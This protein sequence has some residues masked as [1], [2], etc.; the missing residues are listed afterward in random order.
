[1]RAPPDEQ[2]VIAA[3]AEFWEQMLAMTLAPLEPQAE[4]CLDSRHMLGRVNLSGNWTGS[5][6]VR[7][8][9]RL[10]YEATAAMMAQPVA[11]VG[12]ADTLDAAKEIANMIA[13]VIKSSLPRPCSM[14]VPE[15][16]ME[17]DGYGQPPKSDDSLMVAFHHE[18]GN[19]MVRDFEEECAQ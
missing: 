18:A 17:P 1:M 14:T 5:I 11:D 10:A 2:S 4:F 9:E 3:N 7:L 16:E 19:L 13:G 12:E 6:E 15:S 8:A